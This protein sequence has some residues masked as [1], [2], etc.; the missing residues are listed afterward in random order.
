MPLLIGSC[1]FVE[2]CRWDFCTCVATQKCPAAGSLVTVTIIIKIEMLITPPNNPL[3]PH[4][5]VCV[6]VCG[7]GGGVGRIAIDRCLMLDDKYE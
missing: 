3:I 2:H 7:G 1:E 5:S 4:P 6:C